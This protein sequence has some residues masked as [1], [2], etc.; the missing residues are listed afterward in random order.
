MQGIDGP[1]RARV[2][3]TVTPVSDSQSEV[4]IAVDFDG[5]CI[6]KLLVPLI[7]RRQAQHEMPINIASLKRQLDSKT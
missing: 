4:T 5:H 2:E 7:E 6:G 3:V 1:I